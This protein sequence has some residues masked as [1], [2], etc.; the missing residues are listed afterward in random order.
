MTISSE[1]QG[2][3]ERVDIQL[4]GSTF[5]LLTLVSVIGRL[6]VT[7]LFANASCPKPTRGTI[8]EK[9]DLSVQGAGRTKLPI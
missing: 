6:S 7:G 2:D 5:V 9:H 1:T 4:P 8:L 3:E